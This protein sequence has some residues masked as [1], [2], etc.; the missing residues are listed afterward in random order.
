MRRLA[1]EMEHVITARQYEPY[2][3]LQYRFHDA[4]IQASGNEDLIRIIVN[5]KKILMSHE[6]LAQSR[7]SDIQAVFDKMNEEHWHI[8]ALFEA[9]DKEALRA[10]LRDE[11]WNV[12]YASFHTFV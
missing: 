12:K 11:H 1:Q 3:D 9:G 5:L 6:Y 4:F 7:A 8:V 2:H 10:F